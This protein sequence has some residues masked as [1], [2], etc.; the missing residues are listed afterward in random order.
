MVPDHCL[1]KDNFLF[2]QYTCIHDIGTLYS[3]YNAICAIAFTSILMALIFL[4]W[5]RYSEKSSNIDVVTY[6]LATVTAGDY[7]VEVRFPRT[8][9]KD[10]SE[11][12]PSETTYK[13]WYEDYLKGDAKKGISPGISFK[14]RIVKDLKEIVKK[15]SVIEVTEELAGNKNLPS[16]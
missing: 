1:L 14:Q 9:H 8:S 6:D 3:R 12:S 13:E 5:T 4:I 15:Q 10:K 7:T 16:N 11:H 2:V